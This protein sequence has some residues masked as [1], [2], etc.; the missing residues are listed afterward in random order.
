MTL[1]EV[2]ISNVFDFNVPQSEHRTLTPSILFLAFFE[3]SVL[4][5]FRRR[6]LLQ[7]SKTYYRRIAH[8]KTRRLKQRKRSEEENKHQIKCNQLSNYLSLSKTSRVCCAYISGSMR[9]LSRSYPLHCDRP[10]NELTFIRL[11]EKGCLG[12]GRKK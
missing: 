1:L 9:R 12:H 4:L 6:K 2:I 3:F 8:F 7:C 11:Q 5:S 10:N